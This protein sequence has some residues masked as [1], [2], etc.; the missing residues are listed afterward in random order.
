MGASPVPKR[1]IASFLV[2]GW[3]LLLFVTSAAPIPVPKASTPSSLVLISMDTTRSDHLH[4]YGYPLPTS[5]AL[6]RL[7]SEGILFENVITQAVN[8]GPSHATIF[9]GLLPMGH[10]VRFN[11]VPLGV[12]FETLATLLAK[13]GYRTGAFVSGYTLIASQ[14]GLQRGF[15]LYDDQI[16]KEERRAGETVDRAVAWLK[17]LPSDK[18][19]FLFVHLFDPHGRYDP[20]AG[21]ADKFRTGKYEPISSADLIPEY[22]KL[23]LPGGGTSLDPLDYI[24]RYDGEIAYAD[25]QIAR[26]MSQVSDKTAVIVTSDHGESLVEHNYYFSH[27]SRLYEEALRV[28]LIVRAPGLP[29]KGKRVGGLATSA[30]LLPTALTLLQQ[31]LPRRLAGRNLIPFARLGG[32]S[33]GSA[34]ITE[35]RAVPMSLAGRDLKFPPRG[36]IFSARGDRFKLIDYPASGGSLYE[37][38]DLMKDRGEKAPTYGAEAARQSP[39]YQPLD[40]YLVGGSTPEPPDL[41][42][43]AKQKLRSL[44]YVH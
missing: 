1:H 40:L 21:Y 9:T 34:A 5:P 6:D 42:E 17:S 26:L 30:D 43:E 29:L 36:L 24:S 22:Q 13:A 4:C 19:Y 35:G 38:F 44:G 25:A 31:P 11:G 16:A 33:P 27:G 39:V 41:D 23:E 32:I 7:A 15:E 12:E 28:P 10:G 14:C 8:T 18:P 3:S 2:A 20:P 37:L